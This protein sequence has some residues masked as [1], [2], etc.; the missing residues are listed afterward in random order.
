VVQPDGTG[1]P[2]RS[3]ARVRWLL[4]AGAIVAAAALVAVLLSV[5]SGKGGRSSAIV[6]HISAAEAAC[7]DPGQAIPVLFVHGLDSS[8]SDFTRYGDPNLASALTSLPGVSASYFDYH[9]YSSDWVTNPH[10]G[11]ALADDI[12]CLADTSKAHGGSGRV[13][14]VAYSMG[15]LA[16]REAASQTVAGTSVA[17]RIGLAVTIATPNTGSWIDGVARSAIDGVARSAIDGRSAHAPGAALEQLV[18]AQIESLVRQVCAAQGDDSDVLSGLIEVCGELGSA[19]SPAGRALV[20][21]SAQLDALAPLPVSVPLFAVAGDIQVTTPAVDVGPMSITVSIP[22]AIGDLLV[23]PDSALAE[24]GHEGPFSG[25]YTD[26]C[27][28]NLTHLAVVNVQRSGW[29]GCEH[30]EL[31]YAPA[32]TAAVVADVDHYLA[33]PR[34]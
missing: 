8:P 1:T 12:A 24:T 3:P 19:D 27:T 5:V 22:A 26:R 17:S 14:V 9:A 33:G 7:T 11:P 16:L 13:I 32:V 2:T 34:T 31:L 10:I 25:R 29:T 28:E 20:P 15:G 30:G 23:K 18:A 21:G 4:G 6:A